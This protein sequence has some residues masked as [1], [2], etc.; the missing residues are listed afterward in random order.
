MGGVCGLCTGPSEENLTLDLDAVEKEAEMDRLKRENAEF[1]MKLFGKD[2]VLND[3]FDSVSDASPAP[4]IAR[5][6]S[7][8][9]NPIVENRQSSNRP[10]W[11]NEF[12]A[13]LWPAVTDYVEAVMKEKIEAKLKEKVPFRRFRIP[14]LREGADSDAEYACQKVPESYDGGH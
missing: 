6:P 2:A 10:E 1:R 12:L 9:S 8:L 13:S 4:S 14:R 3:F 5:R 11:F 7:W